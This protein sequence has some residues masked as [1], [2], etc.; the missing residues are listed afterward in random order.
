MYDMD[1]TTIFAAAVICTFILFGLIGCARAL[2]DHW[3]EHRS[4]R[5]ECERRRMQERKRERRNMKRRTIGYLISDHAME[6]AKQIAA[7]L[8]VNPLTQNDEFSRLCDIC[9]EALAGYDHR[10][11]QINR[12]L[13]PLEVSLAEET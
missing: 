3:Q 1:L 2:T 9:K 11:R 7:L 4:L 10:A 6:L 12:K 5:Q 13:N 8:G